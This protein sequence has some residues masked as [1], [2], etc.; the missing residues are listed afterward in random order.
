MAENGI[1]EPSACRGAASTN[2][3]V[4]ANSLPAHQV[5]ERHD[6]EGRDRPGW[7]RRRACG[8]QGDA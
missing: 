3:S 5:G 4:G 8:P 7:L 6:H 1:V 2:A